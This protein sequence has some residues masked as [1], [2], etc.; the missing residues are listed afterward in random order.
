MD[1]RTIA[2]RPVRCLPA[3]LA[4]LTS[5]APSVTAFLCS[6]YTYHSFVQSSQGRWPRCNGRDDGAR[7]KKDDKRK[8]GGEKTK[9]KKTLD[10]MRMENWR[11]SG[12]DVGEAGMQKGLLSDSG[13]ITDEYENGLAE[14]TPEWCCENGKFWK[15]IENRKKEYSTRSSNPGKG[16]NVEDVILSFPAVFAEYLNCW[17]FMRDHIFMEWCPCV[18][19]DSESVRRY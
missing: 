16:W 13:I 2:G 7:N 18:F 5:S 3:I 8:K 9:R 4:V 11:T 6:H 12:N 17:W 15:R 1:Y 10:K 19:E 14:Y